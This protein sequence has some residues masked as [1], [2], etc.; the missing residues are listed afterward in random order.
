MVAQM[1]CAHQQDSALVPE[2]DTVR[3]A[4]GTTHAAFVTRMRILG[5]VLP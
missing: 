3:L 1:L 4:V 5:Q 2:A